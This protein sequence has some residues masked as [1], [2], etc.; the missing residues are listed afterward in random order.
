MGLVR[1]GCRRPKFRGNDPENIT[2]SLARMPS[3]RN[4]TKT[5]DDVCSAPEP[6]PAIMRRLQAKDASVPQ[7]IM[8]EADVFDDDIRLPGL[9][10]RPPYEMG[11]LELL[12]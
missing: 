12:L 2:V 7:R 3:D 10:L 1:L 4:S 9:P 8:G 11:F 5:H 6:N